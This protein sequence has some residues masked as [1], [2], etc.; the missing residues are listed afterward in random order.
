MKRAAFFGG[1]Q[2]EVDEGRV[3]ASRRVAD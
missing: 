1:L 2:M 3:A